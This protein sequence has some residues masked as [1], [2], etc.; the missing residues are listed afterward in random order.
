MV[1]FQRRC[2]GTVSPTAAGHAKWGCQTTAS[3]ARG[4]A[5]TA[6]VSFWASH[7]EERPHRGSLPHL[8][9]ALPISLPFPAAKSSLM[10]QL[11][12]SLAASCTGE[13][14]VQPH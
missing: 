10:L 13:H 12:W 9:L 5:L 14:G 4:Q 3:R 2:T 7:R 8:D 11:T 1:A 6:V